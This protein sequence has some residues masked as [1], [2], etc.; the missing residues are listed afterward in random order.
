L[1]EPTAVYRII[2]GSISNTNS[3]RKHYDFVKSRL[4]IKKYFI[5]NY[6]GSKNALEFIYNDFYK[7]SEYHAIKLKEIDTIY[8]NAE[9][10]RKQGSIVKPYYL[11]LICKFNLNE[12]A[13]NT[14]FFFL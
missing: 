11:D 12:Y 3:S 9:N 6:Q 5:D 1:N 14:L 4:C 7:E 8:E 2:S 13:F 10:L